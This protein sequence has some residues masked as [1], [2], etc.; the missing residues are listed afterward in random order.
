MVEVSPGLIVWVHTVR[1]HVFRILHICYLQQWFVRELQ[2][3][4]PPR[5]ALSVAHKPAWAAD[6]GHTE[7]RTLLT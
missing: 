5:P 6:G 2:T 7:L 4:L 1:Y 3:I